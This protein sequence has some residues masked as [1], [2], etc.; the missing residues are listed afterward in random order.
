[1]RHTYMDIKLKD[2]KVLR[3]IKLLTESALICK[4]LKLTGNYVIIKAIIDGLKQ[5]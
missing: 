3:L 2:Q 5:L 4:D 1:M